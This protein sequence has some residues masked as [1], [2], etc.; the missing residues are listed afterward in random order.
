MDD[1]DEERRYGP[2][3][4]PNRIDCLTSSISRA[5]YAVWGSG[6]ACIAVASF[7]YSIAAALVRPLSPGIE[8]FE[9]VAIRSSISL[10]FSYV[11]LR[12]SRQSSPFF[13]QRK[14]IPFLAMRGLI[15][16]LAMDCYYSTIQRLPLGD[17]VSLLFINPVLTAILAWV[18][19]HESLTW[20]GVVGSLVSVI[21]MTLV[22]RP[23][24]LFGGDGSDAEGWS[25]QRSWGVIFGISSAFFAAGAYLTIRMIGKKETP[26]TVA[27]WFHTSALIHSWVFVIIG[28]PHPAVWPNLLDCACLLGISIMSFSANILLNRGFQT[29]SA[30]IA[31]GVN[32]TQ[33]LYSELIGI[34]ILHEK[35]Y[36][37]SIVGA[38]L[39]AGG[40]FS[41]AVDSKRAAKIK[42]ANAADKSDYVEMQGVGNSDEEDEERAG[43]LSSSL[44]ES[45]DDDRGGG[46]GTRN[47]R[48][49][50][51]SINMGGLVDSKPIVDGWRDI[52]LEEESYHA[53]VPGGIVEGF[54]L[55]PLAAEGSL[56][57]INKGNQ[58][59]MSTCQSINDTA[60]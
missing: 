28:W 20:R 4:S 57:N 39:I 12:V 8:V 49:F 56:L 54:A 9:I 6:A 45:H 33:V 51:T 31:S 2:I 21:G 48:N 27:V 46:G 25:S 14:N 38:V 47:G 17:A 36:W 16:A 5:S 23:P 44:E 40:V 22:V 43:L 37:L 30:A 34:L 58:S 13:G 55:R 7:A 15:G 41:V 10:G 19:L 53:E 29:E 50:D 32:M 42:A 52:N 59:S 35:A 60:L 3:D 18:L 1:F 24:F 26:L 11:A